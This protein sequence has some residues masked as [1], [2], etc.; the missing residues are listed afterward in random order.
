V[1]DPHDARSGTMIEAQAR[2]LA[3]SFVLTFIALI[4][5]HQA[6]N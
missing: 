3:F 2:R 4:A 1:Q 5:I 6:F